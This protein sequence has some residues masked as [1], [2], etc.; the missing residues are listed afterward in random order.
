MSG[1][2]HRCHVEKEPEAMA[3]LVAAKRFQRKILSRAQPFTK[4]L[5]DSGILRRTQQ[6]RCR[7]FSDGL[8]RRESGDRGEPYVHPIDHAVTVEREY[9]DAGLFGDG[10]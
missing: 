6:Q 9:R 3:G 1:V 4:A 10:R 7:R 8:W 2:E 5:N